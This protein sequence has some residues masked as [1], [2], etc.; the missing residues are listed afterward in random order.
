MVHQERLQ[1]GRFKV[2][3]LADF[4][5]GVV[6][7]L[8]FDD[9]EQE[10]RKFGIE[11]KLGDTTLAFSVSAAEFGRM[12][13]VLSKL[14]PQAIIYPGQHQ[15]AR[16]AIQSLSG[17]ISQERIFTHLGWRKE[18]SQWLYLHG[19]GAV[20]SGGQV[21]TAQ[22]RLP[23]AL[24]AYQIGPP[25]DSTERV[26]AV[27]DSLRFLSVAPD[28]ITFPL[29]AGV[30]RAAFGL[31][32]YAKDSLLVIDDFAPNGLGDRALESIAEKL[33]RAAGNQQGQS[34]MHQDG[35]PSGAH[36]PRA[37]VLATGEEVPQGQSI[38][39]RLLIIDVGPQEVERATLTQPSQLT[40]SFD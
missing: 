37:L 21:S 10:K 22:V 34:R 15:H 8:V 9:G 35:R 25:Q 24:Q 3:S 28:R 36:A 4:Q 27:R 12:G 38:R 32:F 18:G 7:D 1:N 39:A 2:T 26:Q 40:H 23:T 14:G 29:L 31:A 19:G 11:A 30:Y 17:P 16:A 20:G 13:W 6:S 5:A 33:F